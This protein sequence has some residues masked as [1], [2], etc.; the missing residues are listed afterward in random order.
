MLLAVQGVSKAFPGVQALQNVDFQ[1]EAGEIHALVGENGAGK[2][3]LIKV[4]G[5]VHRADEGQIFLNGSEIHLQN[6]QHA[7]ALGI[8][9]VHQEFNLVPYMTVAENIYLGKMPTGFGGFVSKQEL[10]RNAE[11]VLQD[12]GTVSVKSMV[13]DLTVAE[14][15]LVEI[16]KALSSSPKVLVMDEPTAALNE[17]EIQRLFEIVWSLRERGVGIIYISHHLDEV[18]EIAD[19]C[20]VL[21]DGR[22]VGTLKKEEMSKDEIIRMM[23]GRPLDR[24]FNKTINVKS[25]VALEVRDLEAG[26]LRNISFKIHRGEVLGVAG[27]MGAG[28][29]SLPRALFGLLPISRGNIFLHGHRV[30]IKSPQDAIKYSIGWITEDRKGEGL[31]LSQSVTSNINLASLQ[32]VMGQGGFIQHKKELA[33]AIQFIDELGIRT[34]SPAQ[35]VENLSGGNQQKVVL[36]KWLNTAPEV[37]IMSEPT[38]GIDVGAKVDIYESINELT[39]LG[40]AVLMISSDLPELLGMS[41]RL[42]V[43]YDGEIRAALDTS[44]ATQEQIMY[45]ATGGKQDEKTFSA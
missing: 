9:I 21:R 2:S 3:T 37:I 23:V 13:G 15:Q 43:M 16:G 34:P 4:L 11:N 17:R 39:R 18:L 40:K 31:V 20:T 10:N 1:L 19:R 8:G 12:L 27:L 25:E 45:F 41:D 29:E 32:D 30:N 36:A 44:T 14:M 35:Y 42:I 33:T 22:V 28:Q 5:G 6:P 26:R 7:T 24:M 38:R